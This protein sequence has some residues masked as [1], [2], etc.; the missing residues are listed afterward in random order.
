M[1]NKSVSSA[2]KALEG[3]NQFGHVDNALFLF[4]LDASDNGSSSPMKK[5]K[6]NQELCLIG[7]VFNARTN[8][9]KNFLNIIVIVANIKT[10]NLN[11]I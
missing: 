11:G 4:I 3:K 9:V 8:I 7:I 6:K 5:G 2:L 1:K 10:L